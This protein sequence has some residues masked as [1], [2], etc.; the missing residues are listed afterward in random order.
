M[1]INNGY[2]IL[3]IIFRNYTLQNTAKNSKTY[4]ITIIIYVNFIILAYYICLIKEEI[5]ENKI[6]D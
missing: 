2:N 1:K 3:K 6:I 4:I 5:I